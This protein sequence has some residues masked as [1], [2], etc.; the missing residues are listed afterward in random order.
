MKE[1]CRSLVLSRFD[2]TLHTD[3]EL[4][5]DIKIDLATIEELY[6]LIAWDFDISLLDVPCHKTIKNR[7]FSYS[8][9][10]FPFFLNIT[11]SSMKKI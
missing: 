3:A 10:S 11:Y 5:H 8:L 9:K 1:I 2:L 4:E 6:L 7:I